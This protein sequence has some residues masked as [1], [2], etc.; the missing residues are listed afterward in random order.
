MSEVNQFVS[1]TGRYVFRF[2]WFF[3]IY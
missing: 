3:P 2:M 1:E